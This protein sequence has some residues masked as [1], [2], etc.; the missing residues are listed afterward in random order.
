MKGIRET[1]SVIAKNNDIQKY[2][3]ELQNEDIIID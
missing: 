1:L 2:K 3:Q